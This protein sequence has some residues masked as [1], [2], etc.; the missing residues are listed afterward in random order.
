M[1]MNKPNINIETKRLLI[2][3]LSEKD[4]DPYMNL[5]ASN[6]DISVVY[7]KMPDF[8]DFEFVSELNSE[9]DIY[10]SV[11]RK[12]DSVFVA[13]ASIQN[14]TS[15]VL[16]LGY[17]VVEKY[18]NQGIATEIVEALLQEA[19]SLFKDKKIIVKIN[20]DNEASKKV[21]E[22]CGGKFIKYDDS[23]ISKALAVF[24]NNPDYKSAEV[25]SQE[26]SMAIQR[27]SDAVS[28]YEMP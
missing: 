3:N 2:G 22:K 5:R 15:D 1:N 9:D 11:Y 21:A 18:R 20:N 10:L 19:H 12:S 14:Y 26:I 27:G 8:Q 17:D 23:P 16:E 4:H 13:S 25:D 6:S 7:E 24:A 28:I